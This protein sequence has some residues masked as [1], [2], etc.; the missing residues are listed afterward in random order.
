MEPRDITA[1][2]RIV[3]NVCGERGTYRLTDATR[4]ELHSL[5]N[6]LSDLT[7]YTADHIVSTLTDQLRTQ[8]GVKLRTAAGDLCPI[9][10]LVTLESAGLDADT[11][12]QKDTA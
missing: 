12:E 3:V 10:F 8:Y 2:T 5:A 4:G 11:T 7:G 9:H 1:R 6:T